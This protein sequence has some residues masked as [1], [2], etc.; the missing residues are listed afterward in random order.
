MKSTSMKKLFGSFALATAFIA[1]PAFAS[2][3]AST[4]ASVHINGDGIVHVVGA[5]VTS[6]TGNVVNA[7]LHFKNSIATWAFT[8][9]TSTMIAANNSQTASTTDIHVGDKINVT[10]ALTALGSVVSVNATKIR[11]ITT[12]GLLRSKSGT[13]QS[14]NLTNSTFVL[15]TGDSKTMTIQ[16]NANTVFTVAP[17]TFGGVTS[18]TTLAA[19]ALN[20]RVNVSGVT[21]AD[22]SVLTATKVTVRPS[23][24]TKEDHEDKTK[25]ESHDN[26]NHKGFLK[27]KVGL[28]FGNR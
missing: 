17:T 28:G 8:T 11:D 27:S 12:T 25:K 20:G 6:V 23:M 7:M 13:V 24:S 21:N 10:G 1:M 4:T 15:K 18:T 26:G 9:N 14:V 5:E 19:L 22:G 16:T 2:T 3:N